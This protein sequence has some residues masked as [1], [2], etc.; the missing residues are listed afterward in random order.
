[1]GKESMG[2]FLESAVASV[3]R[4]KYNWQT[5]IENYHLLRPK[6]IKKKHEPKVSSIEIDVFG[7]SDS[8]LIANLLNI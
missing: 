6:S 1:M 7:I 3:L 2:E 4:F 8:S 5:V